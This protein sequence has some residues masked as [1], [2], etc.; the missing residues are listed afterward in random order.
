MEKTNKNNP[1]V[2]LITLVL[3]LLVSLGPMAYF[4]SSEPKADLS[5]ITTETYFR[6]IFSNFISNDQMFYGETEGGDGRNFSLATKTYYTSHLTKRTG[7]YLLTNNPQYGNVQDLEK[8]LFK[9]LNYDR[10]S[11]L[12]DNRSEDWARYEGQDPKDIKPSSEDVLFLKYS[13]NGQKWKLDQ[14]QVK[15]DKNVRQIQNIINELVLN[16]ISNYEYTNTFNEKEENIDLNIPDQDVELGVDSKIASAQITMAMTQKQLD[17]FLGE[18]LFQRQ[19]IDLVVG[20]IPVYILGFFALLAYGLWAFNKTQERTG[21]V[22]FLDFFPWEVTAV[23]VAIWIG[24]FGLICNDPSSIIYPLQDWTSTNRYLLVFAGIFF[25]SFSLLL[26]ASYLALRII[27]IKDRGLAYGFWQKTLVYK[28]IQVLKKIF[29]S[30]VSYLEASVSQEGSSPSRAPLLYLGLGLLLIFLFFFIGAMGIG[31]VESFVL[32]LF[33]AFLLL[34][35]ALFIKDFSAEMKRLIQG[36]NEIVKG[37]YDYQIPVERSYFKGIA[38]NFNRIASN[39][40][41]AVSE[42]VSSAKVQS[43]LITNVSHDLKTPLTSIINYSDLM[44]KEEDPQTLKKYAGVIHEK[45]IHLKDLI[46]NLFEVS[47]T[48]K[49]L[50]ESDLQD[51]DLKDLTSQ[52]L[53]EWED[54]FKTKG[55]DLVYKDQGPLPVCINGNRG[56]RILDNL[57]SNIYKYSLENTRVYVDLYREDGHACICLRNISAMALDPSLDLTGRFTRGDQ[58]RTGTG[59]GLGLAIAKSLL[60]QVKG[61]MEVKVDGDLFKV[62]CRVPLREEKNSKK[63]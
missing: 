45:S 42:A 25:A 55:L 44:D 63:D 59:H 22:R 35:F 52:V 19:S 39:L 29:G 56:Q 21:F 24:L 15:E 14:T 31:G 18:T 46:E 40:D 51:L 61:D 17:N 58:A 54:D 11:Y 30:G 62:T 49:E 53:G 2:F 26:A 41:K 48:S 9:N 38:N 4:Y 43:D 5:W 36:S 8:D 47:Q 60:L 20:L 6:N 7:N 27:Q 1:R 32:F 16:S 12:A 50:R 57:C 10:L 3:A 33:L 28:I 34:V 23:L 37:N 13:Y